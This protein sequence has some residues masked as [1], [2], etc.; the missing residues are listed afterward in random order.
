[1]KTKV[2]TKNM[3]TIPSSI[4]R[5]YGI[6]PGWK[7]DWRKSDQPDEII[8]KVVPDRGERGRRLQGRGEKL[9]PGRDAVAELIAERKTER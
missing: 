7:L 5:H 1:M 9:G 4:A 8:I 3:I 2:T 6:M